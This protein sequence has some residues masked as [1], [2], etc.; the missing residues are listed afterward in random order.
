MNFL[1]MNVVQ[2]SLFETSVFG[3]LVHGLLLLIVIIQRWDNELHL[4]E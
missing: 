3:C 2:Y 4:G 1:L